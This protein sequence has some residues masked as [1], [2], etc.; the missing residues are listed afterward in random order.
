MDEIAVGVEQV[1]NASTPLAGF[2]RRRSI[3]RALLTPA[4]F[5]E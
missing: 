5:I 3:P 4:E 1:G 2:H